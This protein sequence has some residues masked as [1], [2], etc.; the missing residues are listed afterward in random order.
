MNIP[1]YPGSSSFFPGMTPFGYY[2][3]DY[4]FQV[5]ADKVAKFCA[6]RLGYP[7]QEVELQDLNFYAAFE[8]ALTIYG[9]E[10]YSFKLR[11]NYLSLEGAPTSSNLNNAIITPNMANIIRTSEMYGSEAG[12]G[13]NVTYHTGSLNLSAGIQ[14][15]DMD[16]WAV[17]HSISGSDLEIRQVF[18]QQAPAITRFYDPYA[19]TG[20][21]QV[22]LMESFGWGS[23][24]PAVSFLL[25]PLS[26]DLQKIQA[27]EL[28]DQ[29]R[30]SNYSFELVNN[31]LRIFP[32][33]TRDTILIFKYLLKS[34]RL[35]NSITQ[36][37]GNINNVSNVPYTTPTYSQVN[38][39]GRSWIFEYTLALCKEMLGYVRG[40]Y[41]TIPIPN[42]EITLNQNDLITAATAEKQF[43]IE[44]LRGFLDE[45]SRKALLERRSQE[46]EFTNKELTYIPNVIFIA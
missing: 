3:N 45:T 6:Y 1:I 42:Q 41:S 35:A 10:V 26:F 44:K 43:L 21:G 31:Q 18:Y 4:Q 46:S 39:I 19:G 11:D 23:Y 32:I 7:L 25:M 30:K 28:N 34:E 40:K 16:N 36:S 2:D 5:D 33:P 13:G 17:S 22:G 9:N 27:I 38:N 12:V 8:Q 14:N 24:S 37:P 15:Y 20:A 29:I